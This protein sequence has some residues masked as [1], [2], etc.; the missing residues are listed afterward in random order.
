VEAL[1]VLREGGVGEVRG[2]LSEPPSYSAV[3]TTMNILVR[4]GFLSYREEGRKYL[5]SPIIPHDKARQTAVRHLLKTYFDGSIRAAVT[6]L[7]TAD[8]NGLGEAD[9]RELMELIRKARRKERTT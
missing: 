4:K 8:R 3:R 5:Y 1:Y 2:A 7:I 6:G 9:Y